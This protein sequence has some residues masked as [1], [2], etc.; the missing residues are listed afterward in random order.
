MRS[1]FYP[2]KLVTPPVA[3][4]LSREDLRDHVRM[5]SSTTFD[6]KLIR[7]G[8]TAREHVERIAGVQLVTA[9]WKI[10]PPAFPCEDYMQLPMYPLQS[11]ES[12]SAIDTGGGTTTWTPSGDDLVDSDS[13]VRAHVN[14]VSQPGRITL[15]FSQIWPTVVLKTSNPITVQITCGYGG[16][17]DVPGP[18]IQAMLYL[19]G[20]F[21]E[22][23]EAVTI[24]TL[25]ESKE[26]VLGVRELLAPLRLWGF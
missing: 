7:Y 26:L 25:M 18:Y 19:V 9:Q 12:F 21:F 23:A 16:V 20:H 4:P 2:R 3:E 14:T 8:R 13:I 1:L 17:S 15:A 6:D 5:G 24:G 22:N 10:Y 11:V